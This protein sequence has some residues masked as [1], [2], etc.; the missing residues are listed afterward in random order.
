MWGLGGAGVWGGG[1]GQGIYVMTDT[2]PGESRFPHPT[3]AAGT[4]GRLSSSASLSRAP[5]AGPAAPCPGRC[6]RT[7]GRRP[8]AILRA[9]PPP[10]PP[11]GGTRGPPT[12]LATGRRLWACMRPGTGGAGAAPRGAGPPARAPRPG[13]AGS[14][15]LPRAVCQ[16]RRGSH[17]RDEHLHPRLQ[18]RVLP[19]PFGEVLLRERPP[20]VEKITDNGAS[21]PAA[22]PLPSARGTHKCHG[23]K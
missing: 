20:S 18:Q 13:R 2:P 21:V 11:A 6:R 8:R 9:R 3:C 15:R 19:A 5:S 16:P 22:L 23:R 17:L 1:G 10:A 12:P 14:V 4:F 7:P